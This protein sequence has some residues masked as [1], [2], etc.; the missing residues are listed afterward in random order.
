[1]CIYRNWGLLRWTDDTLSTEYDLHMDN[2]IV[3]GITVETIDT[4][5][6]DKMY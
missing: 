1:M 6:K 3:N 4:N 2:M 5:N